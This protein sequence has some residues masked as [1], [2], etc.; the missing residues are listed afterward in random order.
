MI[1]DI[2]DIKLGKEVKIYKNVN[3]VKSIIGDYASI[4]DDSVVNGSIIH[5]FVNL[6]RRVDINR[7]IIDYRTYV[8]VNSVIR[9]STI[10]KYCSLSWNLSIGG[11]NHNY[12][13]LTTHPKWRFFRMTPNLENIQPNLGEHSSCKIGNDVWLGANT[14]VLRNVEIGDGAVIGAGSVVTKDVPPYS[15]VVGNP[16]KVIKKRFDDAIIEELLDIQ[17]WEWPDEV[18]LKNIDLVYSTIINGSVINKL[19]EINNS[20]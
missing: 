13:T 3:V 16:A 2:V 1:Q 10:G 11:K 4:G 12:K 9:S 15:I 14:V 7:S 19:I 8:G 5:K 6:N 20:L 17:W 18:I